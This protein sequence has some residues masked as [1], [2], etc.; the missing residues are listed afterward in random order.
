MNKR[1]M[2]NRP[3]LIA[4]PRPLRQS[5][6]ASA[7]DSVIGALPFCFA[8]RIARGEVTHWRQSATRRP[9]C[10]ARFP[11]VK[12]LDQVVW[13]A[14]KVPPATGLCREQNLPPR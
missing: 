10:E 7:G 11:D 2:K 12:G 5:Y 13:S 9:Y 6:D 4:A 1:E 8:H 3:K 14:L